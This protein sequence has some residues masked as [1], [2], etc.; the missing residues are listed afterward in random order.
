VSEGRS[1]DDGEPQENGEIRQFRFEPPPGATELL[2]VRHGESAPAR[3]GERFPLVDGHGDPPLAAQGRWQ[4]E[5]LGVRLAGEGVHA[6]YVTSLRRTQETAAPLARLTE[7]EPVVEP[8]LRE[9]FLGDWEGGLF[10]FKA[11]E[12]D[13]R[14]I[15]AMQQEEWGRLPGAETNEQLQARV[16]PALRRIVDRHPDQR[17]V[18]VAHGGV[19]G[20][21]LA[22]I[23]GSRPFAFAGNDNGSISHV[24]AI[25]DRWVLRRFNDTGHLAGELSAVAEPPT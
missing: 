21:V 22:H 8:D 18:V 5:Q 14:F 3:P 6:V 15:E 10:R 7:L 12:G 25:G 16:L 19:I 9:V 2:L 20:C 24:V 4:A 1:V 11:A 17:V 13:P 23:A